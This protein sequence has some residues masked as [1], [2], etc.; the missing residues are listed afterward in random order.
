[1]VDSADLLIMES[2]Y[3][4]RLHPPYPDAERELERIVVETYR[5]GG[6][7]IVPAFAVGRTQQLVYTLHQLANR[8]DIPRLPIF[9]DSPLAVNTTDV[10]RTHPECFDA[11]TRQF[12]LDLGGQADP[13]GFQDVTYTRSVEESKRLNFLRQPAIIISASGMAETGRILHHLKNNIENPNNTVL[14][15]GWQAPDTL[16]RRLVERQP[17]VRIFGETYTRRAQV[18]VLDG[19]SGH[20]DRDELLAWAGAFRR[21]PQQIFLVHGEPE[22]AAALAGGLKE[23][24]GMTVFTPE[25]KQSF[26]V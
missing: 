25:W 4:D 11:E 5:R 17:E 19:F 15:A 12:I 1:M 13:F 23:R 2:T 9:V 20:A 10:F 18:E 22:A 6:K 24:Y 8:G 14:I 26:E 3:G 21:R 16:G 7:V